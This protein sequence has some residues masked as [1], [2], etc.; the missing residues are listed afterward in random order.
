MMKRNRDAQQGPC[1]NRSSKYRLFKSE[2]AAGR[3]TYQIAHAHKTTEAD[4][5][6]TLAKGDAEQ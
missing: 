3:N 1:P 5:Y 2:F 4:V 6:N